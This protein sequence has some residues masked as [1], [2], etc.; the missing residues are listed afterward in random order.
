[1]PMGRGAGSPPPRRRMGAGASSMPKA[2]GGC[3]L[4]R[5][6]RVRRLRPGPRGSVGSAGRRAPARLCGPGGPLGHRAAFPGGRALRRTGRHPRH[7]R[8]RPLGPDR[9]TLRVGAY[10]CLCADRRLQRRRPGVLRRARGWGRGRL[11]LPRCPGT[12]RP[13]RATPTWPGT[14]PAAAWPATPRAAASCAPT[15]RRWPPR[16][17]PGAPIP[18]RLQLCRGAHPQPRRWRRGRPRGLVPVAR[19]W[20]RAA[21]GC[22]AAGAADRLPRE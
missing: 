7:A 16:P 15:A 17:W 14:W 18:P 6:Q 5:P 8:W 11:R 12:G 4:L 21:G 20:Q 2:A 1:M 22:C 19:R 13:C 10:I 9:Y 3:A